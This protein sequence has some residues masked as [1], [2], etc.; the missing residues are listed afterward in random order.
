VEIG[1]TQ[2]GRYEITD[3]LKAGETLV[4]NGMH[5]LADGMRVEV[6]RIE[7]IK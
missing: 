2:A 4:V 1:V 7:D 6:V 5:Y 3:G